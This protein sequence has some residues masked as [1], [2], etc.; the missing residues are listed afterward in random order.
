MKRYVF[1]LSLIVALSLAE[2]GPW[3]WRSVVVAQEAQSPAR[4]QPIKV[5]VRHPEWTKDAVIYE[6][7]VRQHSAA[8][9]L[10]A[11]TLDL[12]RLKAL[13]VDILWLM[14]IHPI[15]KVNRKGRLGSYYSVVD[16]KAVNPEFGTLADLKALVNRARRLGMYVI[17]DWVGNHTAWD[18]VWARQHP[19]WYLKDE[20]GEFIS[21]KD[22]T[23]VIQLDYSN[24]HL[25]EAM[26]DAMTYWVREVGIDGYRCDVAGWI[27]LDFWERARRELEQIKPVFLLAENEDQPELLERAFNMNYGWEL[28]GLM[29]QIAQGEATVADLRDYFRQE[30]QIYPPA[31][32]RMHFLTNHDENSW[33]GTIAERL[34]DKFKTFAVFIYTI[35][36]MPLIYSGQEVGNDKRLAFFERDPIAWHRSDLPDFY[37]RLNLLKERHPALWNGNYGGDFRILKTSRDR[38]VFA[39]SRRAGDRELVAA[40]NFSDAPQ[41]FTVAGVRDRFRDGLRDREQLLAPETELYLEPWGYRVWVQR[42]RDLDNRRDPV[43]K[44][45][46]LVPPI[47]SDRASHH[48]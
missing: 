8:G 12:P 5:E 16:Y 21:P 15:G 29:N 33:H 19:E 44:S 40:F 26:L 38:F 41:Q 13:G 42:S 47:L 27:P 11:V 6:V 36:G 24:P 10:E 1:P 37:R 18:A 30:E 28:H 31:A 9:T 34:G 48:D 14:P 4:P 39:F 22:W 17:M 20:N 23:D 43:Q 2:V 45:T 7:N 46:L 3:R 35:P 25:R 32:Y